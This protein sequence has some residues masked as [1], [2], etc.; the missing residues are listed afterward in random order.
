MSAVAEDVE[1]LA[2]RVAAET[3]VPVEQVRLVLAAWVRLVVGER[4]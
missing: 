2:V 1:A 3:Q 4:A